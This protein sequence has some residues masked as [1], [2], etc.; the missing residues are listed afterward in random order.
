IADEADS[1]PERIEKRN[2]GLA[3]DL[4]RQPQSDSLAVKV[5]PKQHTE[6]RAHGF[7]SRLSVLAGS[8]P[9]RRKRS[10]N[11]GS[12]CSARN[13]GRKAT[14]PSGEECSATARSSQRKASSFSPS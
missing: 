6:F 2:G 10:A 1:T 11:R 4:P 8:R 9:I 13:T 5:Q 3:M 7:S 14:P 12:E